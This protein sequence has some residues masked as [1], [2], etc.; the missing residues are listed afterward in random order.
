MK[1]L[2]FRVSFF[3][4]AIQSFDIIIC[5]TEERTPNQMDIFDNKY[6][7]S[8]NF[9]KNGWPLESEETLNLIL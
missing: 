7:A 6:V 9:F 3:I 5:A 8:L 2:S 1:L 4:S